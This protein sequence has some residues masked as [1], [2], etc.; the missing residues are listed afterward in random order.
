VTGVD[1]HVDLRAR[2][3]GTTGSSEHPPPVAADVEA[4][5]YATVYVGDQLARLADAV[6]DALRA[7][8]AHAD[9]AGV[10]A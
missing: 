7:A 10:A 2:A 5:V 3:L 8:A 1:L 4:L 6:Q 9:P